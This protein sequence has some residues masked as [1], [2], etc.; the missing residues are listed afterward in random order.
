MFVAE[1]PER[2][3]SQIGEYLLADAV[4]Y[5]AWNAARS[6]TASISRATSVAD[7]AAERGSYQILTPAEA[8]A[9]VSRTGFP[10]NLQPLVGG[11]PPD[12]AWPYLEA[13]AAAVAPYHR[14]GLRFPALWGCAGP[15][16]P[17]GKRGASVY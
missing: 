11:L 8:A 14:P 17:C 7:L 3:W 5:S 15:I 1:D 4:S 9:L 2:A 13:A 12:V 10:L 16:G 6:G